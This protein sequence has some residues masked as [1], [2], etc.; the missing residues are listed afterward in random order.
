[1]ASP[2][3]GPF[4]P[5]PLLDGAA[6]RPFEPAMTPALLLVLVALVVASS[7]LFYRKL[8]MNHAA[9]LAALTAAKDLE[10]TVL[11]EIQEV[12]T[13]VDALV[14]AVSGAGDSVPQDV[15][16]AVSQ[17]QIAQTNAKNALDVVDQAASG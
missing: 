4:Y 10:A 16:D 3:T 1:M 9:L 2:A 15:Q 8:T 17:L 7:A 12:G 5:G 14:A 13:K 11:T 6:A